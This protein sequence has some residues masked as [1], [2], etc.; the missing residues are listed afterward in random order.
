M[1]SSSQ[2][3]ETITSS[4]ILISRQV[5]KQPFLRKPR[6][7][8]GLRNLSQKRSCV[9][10]KGEAVATSRSSEDSLPRFE[11]GFHVKWV[12]YNLSKV[13]EPE[14]GDFFNGLARF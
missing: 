12:T 10:K 11:Q 9:L 13:S 8:T 3:L 6:Q 2:N 4:K 7:K 1:V 14:A 5:V